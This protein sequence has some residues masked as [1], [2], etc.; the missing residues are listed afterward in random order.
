MGPCGLP[1]WD[2]DGEC[3]RAPHGSHLGCPMKVYGAAQ[4]GPIWS[5]VALPIWF[6]CWQ[7]TW[8][9]FRCPHGTHIGP[10]W[11]ALLLNMG[12]IQA[13]LLLNMGYIRAAILLDMGYIRSALY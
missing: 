1:T 5:P 6:P 7:P 8:G 3:N 13:A 4:M 12:Y 11:A 2:P 9:P 10:K